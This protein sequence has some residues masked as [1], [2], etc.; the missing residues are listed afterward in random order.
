MRRQL[1]SRHFSERM[2]T[3]REY[4]HFYANLMEQLTRNNL[5][6]D[7]DLL[8]PFKRNRIRLGAA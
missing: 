5:Q 3:G 1:K 4:F 6:T 2:G 8:L 7:L